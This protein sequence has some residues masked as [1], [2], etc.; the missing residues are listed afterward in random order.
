[1]WQAF[2]K[3]LVSCVGCAFL[4]RRG[5]RLLALVATC[6]RFS[7]LRPRVRSGRERHG[8]GG[9]LQERFT[10]AVTS[11][12]AVLPVSAAY[13]I[14]LEKSP[15]IRACVLCGWRAFE[16][17]IQWGPTFTAHFGLQPF[18]PILTSQA[19]S[20]ENSVENSFSLFPQPNACHQLTLCHHLPSSQNLFTLVHW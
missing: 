12:L 2:L 15:H 5:A 11:T 8:A 19:D 17:D 3:Y 13:L 4:G 16:Q 20:P 18:I 10:G 1:M 14:A 6:W 7:D 9:V